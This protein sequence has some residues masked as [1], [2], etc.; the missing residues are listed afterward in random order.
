MSGSSGRA[1]LA[2]IPAREWR[3]L[4]PEWAGGRLRV[5]LKC[6]VCGCEDHWTATRVLNPNT[7]IPK[8]IQLGWTV[9]GKL[10]C[11]ACTM[12]HRRKP[13]AAPHPK[14][15]EKIE[16]TGQ[17]NVAKLE[18]P[19]LLGDHKR[20]KLNVASAL[21]EYFDQNAKAY[22]NGKSDKSIADEYGV[23]VGFVAS[24]RSEFDLELAEPNEVGE[25]RDDIAA[26]RKILEELEQ[27]MTGLCNRNGWK[28]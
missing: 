28:V 21:N 20:N 12:Q 15:V 13:S 3:G 19:K 22:R 27:K 8:I 24:V 9:G 25:L 26:A 4:C 6:S 23:S 17:N 16:M 5:P 18:T 2:G 14:L 10:L 11:P 7:A 1:I